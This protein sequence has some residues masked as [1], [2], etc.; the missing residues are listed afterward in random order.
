MPKIYK[1]FQE[2]YELRKIPKTWVIVAGK[3]KRKT[4]TK[5]E[6]LDDK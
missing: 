2:F 6:M 3:F 4:K 5:K 1:E